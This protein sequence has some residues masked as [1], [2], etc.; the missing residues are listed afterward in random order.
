MIPAWLRCRFGVTEGSFVIVEERA[1]GVLIRPPAA[2]PLEMYS[3][4]R[5]AESFFSPVR[6]LKDHAQAMRLCVRWVSTSGRSPTT[7]SVA[8][9]SLGA[10]P[11]CA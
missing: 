10:A 6:C 4:E 11:L 2:F 3:P 5:R 7:S 9:Y 8:S 1:D